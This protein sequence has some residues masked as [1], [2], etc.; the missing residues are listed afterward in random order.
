VFRVNGPDMT[1]LRISDVMRQLMATASQEPTITIG[2]ILQIFGVRG[3]AFLI[4]I[5]SLLNIVIF[6]IPFSSILFGVPMVILAAQIVLGLHAPI[7][8]L[9]LRHQTVKRETLMGGLSKSIYGIES[10]EHYIKPR[11]M[12][13]T[14]PALDRVHGG[15]AL[16]MAALVTMPIPVLN[17]PPSIALALLAI[18]MLRRDG[19]FIGLAYAGGCWC[20]WIFKSLGHYA[21]LLTGSS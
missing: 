4:L 17:V 6:M 10:I 12:F 8:P 14:H 20:L 16:L 5:L 1:P 13:L 11:L 2:R 15:F 21:H 7:F 19:I 9:A 3:F 18:G